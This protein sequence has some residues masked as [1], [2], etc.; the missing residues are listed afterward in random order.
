MKLDTPWGQRTPTTLTRG[1]LS[2]DERC[3]VVVVGSG[4]SGALAAYHLA[5]AGAD[6]VIIDKGPLTSGSTAACTALV[7]YE[8]D[9]PMVE[10]IPRLGLADAQSVYR[11]TRGALDDLHD[12]IH[13]TGIDCQL[14]Q[15]PSLYLARDVDDVAHLRHEALAREEIGLEARFVDGVTLAR[16]YGVRAPGAIVSKIA[17]QLDPRALAT[18][19]LALA[20]ARG[21]RLYDRT[22]LAG[23]G[24]S[25]GRTPTLRTARGHLVHASHVVYATGYHTP[26]RLLDLDG[27]CSLMSTYA[28]VTR[29]LAADRLWP[30]RAMLCEMGSP[31]FYARTTAD[32]RVMIGGEDDYELEPAVRAAMLPGKTRR[33]LARLESV[34]GLRDVEVEHAWAATFAHTPDG[35]PL[36]GSSAPGHWFTLGFGGNGIVFG[37]IGAQ[38]LRDRIAGRHHPHAR[39]FGL[40]RHY[41]TA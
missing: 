25:H 27:L 4:V 33:L 17:Y 21:A 20:A 24:A 31:Y 19:L 16:R 1:T 8:L 2:S 7:Q 15:R 26:R 22:A 29:P 5:E 11:A 41:S 38:I 35:L 28:L 32:G 9:V 40:G 12:L 23:A 18:Q 6:V 34:T 13:R 37:L 39:L 14:E 30:E 36:I 10:L 3:D